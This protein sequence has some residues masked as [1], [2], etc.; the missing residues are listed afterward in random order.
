MPAL[1]QRICM[2]HFGKM[3]VFWIR[4]SPRN[5]GNDSANM[6]R[7]PLPGMS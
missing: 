6:A 4:C 7:L 3:L 1:R 5:H 2:Q